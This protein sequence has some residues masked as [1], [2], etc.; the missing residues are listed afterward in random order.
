MKRFAFILILGWLGPMASAGAGERTAY[1]SVDEKGN[2]TYSQ[3]PPGK[4]A[5]PVDISP[6]HQGRGGVVMPPLRDANG[7][8]NRDTQI[9]PSRARKQAQ[10]EARGR[11]I[12]EIV[13]EC[14]RQRGTDCQ[15]PETLRYID[16][17]SIPRR[18]LP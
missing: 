6:A 3:T 8:W 1:K 16:A 5:K 9:D 7:G 15:N 12:A 2:V 11:R 18:R 14:E 10:D 13:A 4:D 17:Q